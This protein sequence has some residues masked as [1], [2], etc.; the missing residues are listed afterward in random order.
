VGLPPWTLAPSHSHSSPHSASSS[1]SKSPSQCSYQFT[2]SNLRGFC[3]GWVDLNC[4]IGDSLVFLDFRVMVCHT[5]SVFFGFKKS[6]WYCTNSIRC[7][8]WENL[9]ERFWTI[10][11]T[12]HES[13]M[14]KGNPPLL[15]PSDILKVVPFL[16][17]CG[18][19]LWT[20][21]LT[22]ARQALYHLNHQPWFVL[23]IF[24]I[25]SHELF[26]QAGLQSRSSDLC[27]LGS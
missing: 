18:T 6:C 19:R 24:K 11:A 7:P 22:L 16:C 17:V 4:D 9:D 8:H 26:P 21:G 27:L 15:L 5:I 20:Q 25:G 3:S 2:A 12:S 13:K 1:L 14:L 23:G 10:F